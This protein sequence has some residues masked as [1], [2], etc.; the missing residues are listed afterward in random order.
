MYIIFI[1]EL[2]FSSLFFLPNTFADPLSVIFLIFGR[3]SQYQQWRHWHTILGVL[4]K[5]QHPWI[6][7]FEVDHHHHMIGV[8]PDSTFSNLLSMVKKSTHTNY[9]SHHDHYMMKLPQLGRRDMRI[10][11]V[12]NNLGDRGAQHPQPLHVLIQYEHIL[13]H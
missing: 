13:S 7:H 8:L 12:L 10:K 2:D 9:P 4:V 1:P 5:Y 3:S 6:F 11:L